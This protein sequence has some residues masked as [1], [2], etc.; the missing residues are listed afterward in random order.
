MSMKDRSAILPSGHMADGAY[1]YD[2]NTGGFLS[3]TY[4]FSQLPP[5]VSEFNA[6]KNGNAF[7]DKQW[8]SAAEGTVERRLP[9]ETGKALYNGVNAS[10]FGND[11]L[12]LF[13]ER[14][15]EAEKLGQR[16]TTDLLTISFS[17]NDSVGHSYG[18]DSPEARQISIAVDRTLGRLFN[19]VDKRI[20][21][22]NVI[23]VMTADHG[24]APAPELLTE[25]RMPGGRINPP[26]PRTFS[27]PIQQALEK[28][29]GP[30]K[31]ISNTAG[32]SP[33]FNY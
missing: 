9:R 20:G 13:A 14:A 29:Y 26:A 4:Y 22:G 15:I 18:P 1:W 30:G 3:S 31:W 2:S 27:D 10:P 5:W 6:Q 12:E 21:L 32:R 7:A 24:V 16:G 23:V 19:Y 33:Y 25:Q 17:S 28:R 8:Q 11:V